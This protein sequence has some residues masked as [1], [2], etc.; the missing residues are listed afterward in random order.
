MKLRYYADAPNYD[1]HEQIIDL[2]YTISDKYGITVEIERVNNRYG[3]IQVFPGDI[4]ERLLHN[5]AK[6]VDREAVNKP[7]QRYSSKV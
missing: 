2:L 6:H 3:S 1:D 4:R 7:A 5:S